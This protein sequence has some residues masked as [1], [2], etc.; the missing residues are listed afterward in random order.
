MTHPVA[1]AE[2]LDEL[3]HDLAKYLLLPLRMLPRDAGPRAM[4]EALDAALRHTRRHGSSH[5]GA[6]E[7]Y[8]RARE[9]LVAAQADPRRLRALDSAVARALAWEEVL[10][11]GAEIERAA[12]EADLA[13]IGVELAAWLAEVSD[14]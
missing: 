3:R 7:I 13:G 4:R 1:L 10:D 14:E 8:T 6:R 2:L 12:L 9:G 5:V 11:N